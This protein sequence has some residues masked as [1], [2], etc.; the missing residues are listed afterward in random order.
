[1]ADEL[2][3]TFALTYSNPSSG[4]SPMLKDT[5]ASATTKITQTTQMMNA[6]CVSVGTSEEDIA[7]G[8][9]TVSNGYWLYLKNVDTTNFVKYGPKSAGNMVEFGRLYS[10]KEAWLFV[11]PSVTLRWIADTAA[12]RVL[13][14]A[15]EK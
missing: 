11:A 12:C 15:Y 2:Q 9:I 7:V 3:I 4:T 8:D 1:M 13:A 10:G 14:K 6:S 5:V